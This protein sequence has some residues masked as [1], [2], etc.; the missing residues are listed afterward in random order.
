LFEKSAALGF[1]YHN[2]PF[3]ET[4]RIAKLDSDFKSD[5]VSLLAG[6]WVALTAQDLD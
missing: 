4:I 1:F 2:E 6:M 5:D 3:E